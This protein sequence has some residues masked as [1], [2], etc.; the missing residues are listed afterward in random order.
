HVERVV[1]R[2][3]RPRRRPAGQRLQH[4]GLH[5][6]KAASP[7]EGPVLLHQPA[8]REEYIHY[9]PIR[10]QVHVPLPVTEFLV[11]ET[12]IFLR[13]GAERL[14]QQ[15]E[16]VDLAGDLTTLG[17]KQG[18][19]DADD[20]AE[21]QVRETPIWLGAKLVDLG[22]HLD[23][24]AE[25][26]Q[27]SKRRLAH[28]PNRDQAAGYGNRVGASL[29]SARRFRLLEERDR[30]GGAMRA[31]EAALIGLD[32]LCAERLQLVTSLQLPIGPLAF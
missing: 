24:S 22:Q 18:A 28:D 20:V 15:D 26:L 2:S 16:V 27:V 9:L 21:I 32:P 1:V 3:K 5:L 10:D 11:L 30:L 6:V 7:K 12:V 14:R 25:I 13:Q 29:G 19:V 23:P 4:R 31:I 8:A 17:P